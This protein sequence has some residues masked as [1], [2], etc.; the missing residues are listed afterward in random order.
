MANKFKLWHSK[1]PNSLKHVTDS[2]GHLIVVFAN[3]LFLRSGHKFRDLEKSVVELALLVDRPMIFILSTE[4][5]E[6]R[7]PRTGL[8]DFFRDQIIGSNYKINM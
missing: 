2:T 4:D 7:K 6:Y 1:V 3:W 8:F 5:D